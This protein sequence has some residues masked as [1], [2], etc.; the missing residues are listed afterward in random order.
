MIIVKVLMNKQ[1]KHKKKTQIFCL[2]KMIGDVVVVHNHIEYSIN[3][4]WVHIKMINTKKHLK[5]LQ[6]FQHHSVRNLMIQHE[7]IKGDGGP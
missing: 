4:V 3:I 6:H 2:Y 5:S 7:K 1:K